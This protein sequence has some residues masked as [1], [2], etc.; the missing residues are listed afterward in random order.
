MWFTFIGRY[1]IQ[2]SVPQNLM[3]KVIVLNGDKF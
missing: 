3:I 1:I 2:C